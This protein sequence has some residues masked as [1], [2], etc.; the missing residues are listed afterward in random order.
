[1][2]KRSQGKTLFEQVWISTKSNFLSVSQEF[3]ASEH[4]NIFDS[5]K[6]INRSGHRTWIL[7]LRCRSNVVSFAGFKIWHF[8]TN[9][10]DHPTL[11]IGVLEHNVVAPSQIAVGGEG[12]WDLP[13]T[14]LIF[15]QCLRKWQLLTSFLGIVVGFLN[16]V[17]LHIFVPVTDSGFVGVFRTTLQ[18]LDCV[19]HIFYISKF[20]KIS[21]KF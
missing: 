10:H 18:L 11:S 5:L 1:M 17:K 9:I 7:P 16:M 14:L 13:I 12:P 4:V 19:L 3:I 2:L 20:F 15:A 21:Y 8:I 6:A